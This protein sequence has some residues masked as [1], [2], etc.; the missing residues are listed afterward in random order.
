M[1]NFPLIT[2]QGVLE[3]C[4][5]EELREELRS[6]VQNMCQQLLDK[7]EESPYLLGFKV[8]LLIQVDKYY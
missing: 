8:E 3:H 5:D 1:F 4:E 2:L 6:R 7:G